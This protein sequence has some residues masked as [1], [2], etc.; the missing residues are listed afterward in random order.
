MPYSKVILLAKLMIIV[1]NYG[2]S[3]LFL[4]FMKTSQ[5]LELGG[6]QSGFGPEGIAPH[7]PPTQYAPNT[8][9]WLC[10]LASNFYLQQFRCVISK[11]QLLMKTKMK[12]IEF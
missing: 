2:N 11:S 1:L 12:L 3:T 6:L 7:K 9:Y 8:E 4:S 10:L 5:L